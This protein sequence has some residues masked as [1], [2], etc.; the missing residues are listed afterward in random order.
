MIEPLVKMLSYNGMT[1]WGY[2]LLLGKDVDFS[3]TNTHTIKFLQHLKYVTGF[4]MEK[5][6]PI[7]L[8]DYTKEVCSLR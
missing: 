8:E 3:S 7:S 1:E 2:N 5:S 6:R 4:L